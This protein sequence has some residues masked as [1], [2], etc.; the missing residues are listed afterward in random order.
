MKWLWPGKRELACV[1]DA[2]GDIRIVQRGSKRSLVFGE[3]SEQSAVCMRR[4]GRL[5][6]QYSRAMLLGALCHP[7]PE[8]ALFLGLGAG[9]LVRACLDAIPNLID[10]EVIELRP[11]VVELATRYLAFTPDERMTIRL[12]DALQL[13]NTAERADLIF[14]DLYDE[15]GPSR[16]HMAWDFLQACQNKLEEGGWLVINQW[17][18][19]NNQP[20]AAPLLYGL[21]DRHY[22]ELPVSEG[23]VI[24][25]I[26]ASTEQNLP[27]AQLRE[28][29]LAV[30][31]QMGFSLTGLLENIRLAGP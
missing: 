1:T 21:Y 2:Q 13:L 22:W 14:L 27:V 24:L 26:P 16:G 17:A 18:L 5:E 9:A 10:A 20:L 23:N 19:Q 6:Y 29:A 8:T 11:A 15:R 30:G 4:P 7:Q 3:E 31:Q 28:R 12:G 25:L